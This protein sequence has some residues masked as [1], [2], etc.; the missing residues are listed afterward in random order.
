MMQ[1]VPND[2]SP[3]ASDVT[4]V[5]SIAGKGD[6]TA[7]EQLFSIVYAALRSLAGKYLRSERAG[8]T[9]QPTALVHEAFLN[10]VGGETP[11]WRDR[12]HFFAVAARAMRRILINHALARKAL[13]RGGRRERTPLTIV[14]GPEAPAPIDLLALDEAISKLAARDERQAR[15]VELRFFGGLANKEIAEMLGVS[16]R[17]IEGEWSMARAWLSRALSEDVSR[18]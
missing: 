1:S 17:T 4:R 10:L 7:T 16:L 14:V 8:H 15:V 2:S 12:A 13:K 6:D 11:A 3:S 9:L 18:E 5:L